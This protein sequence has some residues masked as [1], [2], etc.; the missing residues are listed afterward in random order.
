MNKYEINHHDVWVKLRI[1][2]C[3]SQEEAEVEIKKQVEN[4]LWIQGIS[5]T[6]VLVVEEK[7]S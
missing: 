3:E 4:G 5:G 2:G 6:S 7:Q 1:W